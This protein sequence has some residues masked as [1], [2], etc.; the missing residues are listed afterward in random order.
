MDLLQIIR[1]FDAKMEEEEL[2]TDAGCWKAVT[3]AMELDI[4]ADSRVVRHN[5]C[6]LGLLF[7][8]VHTC[9]H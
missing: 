9:M 3:I 4:S 6:R 8:Y 7:S 2:R 1:S 5:A